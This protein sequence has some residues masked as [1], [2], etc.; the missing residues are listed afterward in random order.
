MRKSIKTAAVALLA[1][2]SLQACRKESDMLHNYSYDSLLAFGEADRSFGE[3]FKVLWEALNSN[4]ALWDYEAE[5]GLDWD[6][7]Y[8]TYY[9]KFVELDTEGITFPDDLLN[10]AIEEVSAKYTESN[11]EQSDE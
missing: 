11:G 3:K 4:Y 9:P 1:L 7:V 5:H 2:L 6:E 10:V 8:D